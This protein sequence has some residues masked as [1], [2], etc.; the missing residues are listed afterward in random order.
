[1]RGAYDQIVC[2][3]RCKYTEIELRLYSF[4]VDRLTQEVTTD[5]IDANNHCMDACRYALDPL[6]MHKK[7]SHLF[8]RSSGNPS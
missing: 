3:P 7:G 6:G 1:M 8:G 4:K 2:H 5:I